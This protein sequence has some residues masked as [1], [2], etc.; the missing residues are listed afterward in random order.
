MGKIFTVVVLVNVI[1]AFG[2]YGLADA[3]RTFATRKGLSFHSRL[4]LGLRKIEEVAKRGN[5]YRNSTIL[6]FKKINKIG[7]GIKQDENL[8]VVSKGYFE[9]NS[10][11]PSFPV[12]LYAPAQV[13]KGYFSKLKEESKA[14]S[15]PMLSSRLRQSRRAKRVRI[16]EVCDSA[17]ETGRSIVRN[18]AAAGVLKNKGLAELV[19]TVC[20]SL[21]NSFP[22]EVAHLQCNRLEKNI[23][24]YYDPKYVQ[25][26]HSNSNRY[27]DDGTAFELVGVTRR[28]NIALASVLQNCQTLLG[29]DFCDTNASN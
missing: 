29:L 26:L 21:G 6:A 1:Y 22:E 13:P 17:V 8:P 25:T 15:S 12:R 16:C 10:P 23:R 27:I 11:R 19:K 14:V 3:E 24:D 18:E 4:Q 2:R 7:K 20:V 9:W 28:V 5:K